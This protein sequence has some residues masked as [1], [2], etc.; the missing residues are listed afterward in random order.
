MIIGMSDV[1]IF[2]ECVMCMINIMS[3][4]EIFI[5]SVLYCTVLYVHIAVTCNTFVRPTRVG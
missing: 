1:G 5:L 4:A 3:D 2:H